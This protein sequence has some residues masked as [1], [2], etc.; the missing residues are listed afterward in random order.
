MLKPYL[1]DGVIELHPL[2]QSWILNLTVEDESS[3]DLIDVNGV[4]S[5]LAT[6]R[7]QIAFGDHRALYLVW[8]GTLRARVRLESDDDGDDEYETA[9]NDDD[10]S[11][12][13]EPPVPAGLKT[14]DGGLRALCDFFGIDAHLVDAA[15]KDSPVEHDSVEVDVEG[16]IRQLPR[17]T[18][19]GY[20]I[21]L[22]A[23]EPDL[24]MKLK[25]QLTKKAQPDV[26]AQPKRRTAAELLKAAQT[27]AIAGQ[28]RAQARAAAVR[29]KHL[30][31]VERRGQ[32]VW[33]E[34]EALLAEKV[35]ARHAE[36]TV[37]LQDLRDLAALRNDTFVFAA[38]MR[39]IKRNCSGQLQRHRRAVTDGAN[40]I[41]RSV[42]LLAG[43]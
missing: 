25:L 31:D 26:R 2:G 27:L 40:G 21:R 38:R 33:Q 9:D 22:L 24:A 7:A 17:G 13:L 11:P 32:S 39:A 20:L 12:N 16:A 36:A 5:D 28:K 3:S 4:L 18:C 29:V 35:G 19:D 43:G 6:V 23:G 15:A 10:E 37:L 8:L 34:V 14:R 1:I 30:E 41:K 42:A